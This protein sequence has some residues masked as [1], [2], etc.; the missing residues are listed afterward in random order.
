M[1]SKLVCIALLFTLLLSKSE[2]AKA[3]I[4]E[5]ETIEKLYKED[6]FTGTQLI[7]SQ[8]TKAMH[9]RSWSFEIQHRFGKVGPDSTLIQQFLGF[10][11]P[12]NIRFAIG[13]SLTDR[14][15]IKLGRTNFQKTVDI[16]G[17]YLLLK[18]TADN[19][20]PV[21]VALFFDSS[22]KTDKFPNVQPNSFFDDGKTPFKYK[23]SHRLNY[24][25]QIIVSS[26]LSDKISLQATPIFIYSN[27]V[28]PGFENHTIALSLG[29][30]Y[31]YSLRSA[32]LFEYAHVFNNRVNQF[33]DPLSIGFEF[34]TAGHVFQV[35][36]STSSKILENH[37][38]TSS[39]VDYSKGEFLL[40]FNIQRNFFRKQ[41][42]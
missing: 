22:I 20:M 35:F 28:N 7:N 39:A 33:R 14:G 26:K 12:S 23:D 40:G 15:Y 10:D 3:Q 11:L 8:T 41:K 27:L 4:T 1:K 36:A 21:S 30:R 13:W 38:Y 31:K 37:I 29:G 19:K 2:F 42:S 24:N 9:P 25:S 16:E 18:Q 34:G 32:V 17:K 6:V 5:D